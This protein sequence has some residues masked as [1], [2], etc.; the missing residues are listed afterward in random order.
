MVLEQERYGKVIR[1]NADNQ[2][3]QVYSELRM[4]LAERGLINGN[5][6][7]QQQ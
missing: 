4:R 7:M 5:S 1:V 6:P 3:Q 2:K